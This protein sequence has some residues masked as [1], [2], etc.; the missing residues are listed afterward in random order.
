MA[1]AKSLVCGTSWTQ[2]R[3]WEAGYADQAKC[4]KCE[5]TLGTLWH[6]HHACPATEAYRQ[7]SYDPRLKKAANHVKSFGIMAGE[8]FCRGLFPYA[9]AL[10]PRVEGKPQDRV[11]W[12]RRPHIG[13]MS[14]EIYTDGSALHLKTPEAR[15]AGWAVIMVDS[16]G[17]LCRQPMGHYHF[18]R[19]RTRALP[20]QKTLRFT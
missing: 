11:I 15:R 9:A 6:R 4:L 13:Y 16:V 14:D 8:L 2:W 18:T 1:S 19:A 10:A 12:I 5:G 3:L 17:N 20:R 7:H